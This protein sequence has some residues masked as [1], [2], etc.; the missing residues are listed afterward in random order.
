MLF[1]ALLTT[2]A[3][4]TF[5]EGVARRPQLR[6]PCHC[7]VPTGGCAAMSEDESGEMR[8]VLEHLQSKGFNGCLICGQHLFGVGP[9]QEIVFAQQDTAVMPVMCVNCGH[10]IF[11]SVLHL[12]PEGV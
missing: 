11:V 2:R 7:H 12:R 1:V 5:Q 6:Y 3:G 8:D 10:V 4:G 9:P